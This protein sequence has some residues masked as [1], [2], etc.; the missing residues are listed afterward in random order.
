MKT[1]DPFK[2]DDENP[3]LTSGDI[4][5]M[6]PARE[7]LGDAWVESQKRGRGRPRM[8]APK[9]KVTLR[10]DVEVLQFFREEGAGWQTRL[11]EALKVVVSKGAA[12]RR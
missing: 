6:R 3:E 5:R 12:S 7:V 10:L 1:P 9:E 11:N 2:A 8:E 4:A